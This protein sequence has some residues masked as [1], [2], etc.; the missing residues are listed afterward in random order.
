[1]SAPFAST[2]LIAGT[3][4]KSPLSLLK[5]GRLVAPALVTMVWLALPT[6]MDLVTEVAAL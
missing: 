3:K 4:G 1:M 2:D 6:L 5:L